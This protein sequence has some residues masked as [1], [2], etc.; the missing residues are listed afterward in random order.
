[1]SPDG[2]RGTGLEE[3]DLWPVAEPMFKVPPS[4]GGKMDTQL[5]WLWQTGS[6]GEQVK[7]TGEGGSA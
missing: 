7:E 5:R 4:R 3:Q 6:S 1:M 2:Y